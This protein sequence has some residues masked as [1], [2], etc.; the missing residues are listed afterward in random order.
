MEY[1]C[2]DTVPLSS[3]YPE[4][5]KDVPSAVMKSIFCRNKFEHLSR[6]FIQTFRKAKNGVTLN[7]GKPC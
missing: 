3:I 4:F 7:T 2:G 1:I 5:I 6:Q